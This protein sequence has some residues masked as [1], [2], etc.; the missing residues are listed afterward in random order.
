MKLN[1]TDLI[2]TLSDAIDAVEKQVTGAA[3]E[4]GKRVGYLCERMSANCGL[5]SEEKSDLIGCAI[6]HDNADG[7]GPF[8][9]KEKDT[10]LYSEMIHL[11]DFIDIL[12]SFPTMDQFG[13][14]EMQKYVASHAGTLFSHRAAHLMK[15]SFTYDDLIRLQ[16]KG[17]QACLKESVPEIIGEYRDDEIR[18]IAMFFSGIVDYKSSFTKDHSMGVANKAYTMAKYYRWDND[19]SIRFYLAGALHDIGKLMVPNTILEK[20]AKLSTEEFNAMK[21]HAAATYRMLSRIPGFEE[22]AEWAGNHHEKLDGTGY[23][24]GLKAEDLTFEDRLM[25]CLDIYQALTEKRPYKQKYSYAQS[26]DIMI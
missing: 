25:G 23:S 18:N 11:G 7:T 12:F 5:T 21:D 10:T 20:P 24:R 8:H 1:Y 3:S 22:I 9:L 17:V 26:I 15:D 14:Q 4:H 16:Q 13:Y 19:K 6:L 2:F